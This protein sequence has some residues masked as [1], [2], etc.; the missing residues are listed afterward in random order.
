[1]EVITIEIIVTILVILFFIILIFLSSFSIEEHAAQCKIGEENLSVS[2]FK[3]LCDF[4]NLL[5]YNF[6]IVSTILRDWIMS[7]FTP[8]MT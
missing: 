4:S 2:K 3:K 7:V 6:I 1:M 8:W 5:F